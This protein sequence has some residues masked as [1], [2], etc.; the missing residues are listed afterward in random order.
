MKL[1]WFR[2]LVQYF[3]LWDTPYTW[4]MTWH[5]FWRHW[6]MTSKVRKQTSRDTKNENERRKYLIQL[7]VV[8]KKKTMVKSII[9]MLFS[10][11]TGYIMWHSR[12][13]IYIP[14]GAA[15]GNICY[16]TGYIMWHSRLMIIYFLR[17]RL[18]E[19]RS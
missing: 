2:N 7:D 17:L 13:R 1:Y 15:K 4:N 16:Q 19:Y 6:R 8:F 10:Y 11:Q 18:R 12:L 14:W 9:Y 3:P 5:I